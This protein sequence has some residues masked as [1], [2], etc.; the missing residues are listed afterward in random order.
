MV[1]ANWFEAGITRLQVV[2]LGLWVLGASFAW[3]TPSTADVDF[4]IAP[5]FGIS[6]L[7]ADTDGSATNGATTVFFSGDDDDA[8][9]LLGGAVGLEM[10]MN[11]IFPRE[12]LGDTRLPSWPVRFELEASGLRDYDF[13]TD[14]PGAGAEVFTS[15]IDATTLFANSWFDIPMNTMWSPFQ[16]MFGLGRQ[17][18]VRAWLD[19]MNFYLGGG[20]GYTRLD[21]KGT[22][23]VFSGN[24]DIDD[25]AWNVGAG[26][27][28]ELTDRVKLSTGYR[29]IG[30]APDSGEQTLDVDGGGAIGDIDYDLQVHEFRV[31][32]QIRIF[33]FRGAWR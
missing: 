8:A 19:P 10:P 23:N 16:Y 12:W 28:Y 11:E 26:F 18:R 17:P 15:E 7:I 30:L 32:I 29:Y 9:P 25:F 13:T 2:W 3:S 4:Y 6:A 22:D 14:G 27:S 33:S 5:Q 21:I 31:G 20:V 24:D 1:R